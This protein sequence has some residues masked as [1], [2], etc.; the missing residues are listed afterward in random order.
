MKKIWNKKR[1]FESALWDDHVEQIHDPLL[2]VAPGLFQVSASYF[3]IPKYRNMTLLELPTGG[4]LVHSPIALPEAAMAEIEELGQPKLLFVSNKSAS[5]RVDLKVY[6]ERYPDAKIIV[7]QGIADSLKEEV[8]IE[9]FVE[10][11]LKKIDSGFLFIE[12][13]LKELKGTDYN[14]HSYA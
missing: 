10:E 12:P 3:T 6:R 1:G 8:E 7:P 14:T 13:P 2:E 5:S 4:L 9:G 11:E